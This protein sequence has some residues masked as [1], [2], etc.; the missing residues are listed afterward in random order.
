MLRVLERTKQFSKTLIFGDGEVGRLTRIYLHEQGIEI[1]GFIV[2]GMPTKDTLMDVPLKCIESIGSSDSSLVLICV[3]KIWWDEVK[4]RLLSLGF[5]D[6]ELIDDN[7][8]KYMWNNVT[9]KDLYGDVEEGRNIN[10]LLYHRV[11][12]LDTVYSLIVNKRNFEEQLKYIKANYKLLRCDDNWDCIN[13]KSIAITFDDGYVDFYKNVYPL[14]RKYEIPATVFVSTGNIDSTRMFWWDELECIIMRSVLPSK[15]NMCDKVYR[16]DTYLNRIEL[17]YDIHDQ[18]MTYN[19]RDRDAEIES[20]RKQ[21][22]YACDCIENYRTMSREEIYEISKCPFVTIGAHTVSHILCDKE[23]PDLVKKEIEQSKT[24]LES[25]I[26]REV[27][28]FAYPNGNVGDKTRNIL[29]DVGIERAFTCYRACARN[30][31]KKYDIP[32][33]PVLNWGAEQNERRFK[34]MWQT[35]KDI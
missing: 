18:I 30:G 24:T 15:I 34:G 4:D 35:G 13:E 14:L 19:Y 17:L 31:E 33:S 21:T 7:R 27:K 9:F 23:E 25:I 6:F 12:E 3:H 8:Q 5:V 29:Q 16:I 20:L 32:R 2:S 10:T 1:S 28:L 26:E 11:A 22:S